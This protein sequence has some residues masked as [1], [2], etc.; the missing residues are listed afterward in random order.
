[1][2]IKRDIMRQV[3]AM[4]SLREAIKDIINRTTDG[5]SGQ[6]PNKMLCSGT[7]RVN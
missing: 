4:S 1:M 5:L 2:V 6:V 3:R 7:A